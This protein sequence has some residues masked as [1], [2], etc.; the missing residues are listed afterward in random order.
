MSQ[1]HIVRRIRNAYWV[2]FVQ[3]ALPVRV[4]RDVPPMQ[5]VMILFCVRQVDDV[6]LMQRCLAPWMRIVP[7]RM[8]ENAKLVVLAPMIQL[9]CVLPTQNVRT[10]EEHVEQTEHVPKTL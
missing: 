1:I 7:K 9:N 10:K 3:A 5:I 6:L 2:V 4:L 8:R